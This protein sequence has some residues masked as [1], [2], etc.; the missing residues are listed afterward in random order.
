MS[1]LYSKVSNHCDQ[2]A[3]E[4]GRTPQADRSQ[5]ESNRPPADLNS[6]N[7]N[8]S[9]GHRP[10]RRESPLEPQC[11]CTRS[12]TP[13][14]QLGSSNGTSLSSLPWHHP[15][16]VLFRQSRLSSRCR[17]LQR[18]SSPHLQ[19]TKCFHISVNF[20]VLKY[21]TKTRSQPL[22]PRWSSRPELP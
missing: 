11:L 14:F 5:A 12:S 22:C 20:S 19:R 17:K 2:S 10:L 4:H 18:A 9:P 1:T 7:Q 6:A 15:A 3:W 13:E 16:P 21:L 8:Q